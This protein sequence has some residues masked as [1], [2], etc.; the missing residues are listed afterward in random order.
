MVGQHAMFAQDMADFMG[1]VHFRSD[2][3]PLSTVCSAFKAFFCRHP[4]QK[5][6]M[7]FINFVGFFFYSFSMIYSKQMGAK[8]LWCENQ[9]LIYRKQLCH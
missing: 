7:F 2:G 5:S 9:M 4:E 8:S 1:K 6:P 3:A